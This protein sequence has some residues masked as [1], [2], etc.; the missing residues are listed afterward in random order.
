MGKGMY[1]AQWGV[2]LCRL[3]PA[4]FQKDLRQ[5]EEI[6]QCKNKTI[7]KTTKIK[8]QRIF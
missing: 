3:L 8:V 5:P 1:Q 4:Y 2:G 7:G 6:K